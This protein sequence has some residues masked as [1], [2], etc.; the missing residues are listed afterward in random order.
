MSATAT[1][2]AWISLLE[3]TLEGFKEDLSELSSTNHQTVSEDSAVQFANHLRENVLALRK[4]NDVFI[5]HISKTHSPIGVLDGVEAALDARD[6]ALDEIEAS[7]EAKYGIEPV[8]LVDPVNALSEGVAKLMTENGEAADAPAN[9]PALLLRTPPSSSPDHEKSLPATP[10]LADFNIA[11]D[12]FKK[13]PQG[14]AR[15]RRRIAKI[16]QTLVTPARAP[17]VPAFADS[18]PAP[19]TPAFETP[20]PVPASV[21]MEDVKMPVPDFRTPAPVTP[22]RP[23]RT[24]GMSDGSLPPTPTMAEFGLDDFDMDKMMLNKYSKGK[25]EK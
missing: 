5:T 24:P 18:T 19:P 4:K 13:P 21:S 9:A 7:L 14:T 1:A 10:T 11:D 6:A 3:E 12:Y 2:Q 25:E 23:P 22:A 17:A 16:Q 15:G 8:P 20:V